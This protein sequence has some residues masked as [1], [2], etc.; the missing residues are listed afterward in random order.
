MAEHRF[1]KAEVTGSSPVGGSIQITIEADKICVGGG[2]N[3]AETASG[4]G[5]MEITPR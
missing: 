3:T 4:R 2:S 5:R 1:G